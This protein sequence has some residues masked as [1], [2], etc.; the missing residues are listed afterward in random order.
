MSLAPIDELLHQFK[1]VRELA[2]DPQCKLVALLGTI[3]ADQAIVKLER[4]HVDIDPSEPFLDSIEL[5]Q[6]NDIYYWARAKLRE[7]HG[8]KL[9]VICPA[10]DTH[11]RKYDT[12]QYHMVRETPE[13]YQQY[14]VPYIKLQ[15]GDRI[16]WV[17]NILFEGKEL[18]T[19]VYHDKHPETGMVIL[20]D[21]KWDKVT[22]DALYLT[23]IVNTKSIGCVRDLGGQHLPWLKQMRKTIFKVVKEKYG[24]AS[25]KVRVFVHYQPS[26]YHFHI[27]IVNVVHPGLGNGITAGKAILLDD[28]ITNLEVKA[29]YYQTQALTYLLGENHGLWAIDGYREAHLKSVAEE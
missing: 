27:H 29:D 7:Q 8:T 3:G 28:I 14:A 23:G 13:M 1:F 17:Y 21:M 4:S 5:I 26:Y 12:Q 15:Q 22:M 9:D 19:F 18:E 10:T 11:I 24:L 25:D 16:K 2:S 6:H 20:P